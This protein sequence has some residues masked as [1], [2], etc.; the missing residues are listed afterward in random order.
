MIR[1][2]SAI[3][4]L[5][6]GAT[7]ALAQAT[8]GKAIEERK[9]LM[10]ETNGLTKQVSGM[11]KGTEPFDLAKAQN[12][13]KVIIA[14]TTKAMGLFP[15]D[16]KEGGDTRAT[17]AVWS[18]RADFKAKFDTFDKAAKAAAAAVKDEASL[19]AEF[20]KVS[21]ACDACHKDYR[22]PSKKQ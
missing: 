15:D 16:S 3:A 18:N 10:K 1:T 4:L 19:K 6:V 20:P 5:A 11:T 12:W 17:P 13:A 14:N 22:A 8:G 21:E 9:A 7:L 2:V